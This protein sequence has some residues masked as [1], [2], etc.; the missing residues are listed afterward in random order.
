MKKII[1][2][3]IIICLLLSAIPL[4]ICGYEANENN[5]NE[6]NENLFLETSNNIPPFIKKLGGTYNSDDVKHRFSESEYVPGEMII[7]FKDD[8]EVSLSSSE[9][10][11]LNDILT[12]PAFSTEAMTV[13]ATSSVNLDEVMDTIGVESSNYPDIASIVGSI[14]TS[15]GEVMTTGIESID[16]LNLMCGVKLIEKLTE[17][18]SDASLSNVYKFTFDENV[19]IMSAID[20][21]SNDSNVEFAE[22]NYIYQH[23]EVSNELTNQIYQ[24]KPYIPSYIP[25]DPYFDMQW[26]LHNVGQEGGTPG[27]DIDAPEAWDSGM[28]DDDIVI[29]IVDS[30]VDYTNPD[31]GG[32]TDGITE[33]KFDNQSSHPMNK[34]LEVTLDFAEIFHQYDFDAVSLHFSKIDLGDWS[35]ITSGPIDSDSPDSKYLFDPYLQ[36]S[37]VEDFWTVFTE[38]GNLKVTIYAHD[39]EN[40]WGYAIDKVKLL[41]WKNVKQSEGYQ[42]KFVDGY[43]FFCHDP[44][45]MDDLGHGTHCAGIAAATIDN[46]VGVAGIAGNCKI[47][48]I[49]VGSSM[50]MTESAIARGIIYAANHGAD[51]ISMSIGGPESKLINH[52]LDYAYLKGVVLIAAAGNYDL[53]IKEFAYPAANEKVIAVAATNRYD[54]KAGFS[55]YGSWVDLAAP[56]WDILSLRAY[57]TDMYLEAEGYQPGEYFVPAFDKNAILYRAWG[58]SMSCPH[59]AGVVALILS[60][61]S[62]LKPREVLTILKSSCDPVISDDYIGVGR[63]NASQAV[64]KTAPVIAEFDKSID[65]AIVEGTTKIKGTAKGDR[66]EEYVVEWG[67]GTYPEEWH[68]IDGFSAPKNNEVLVSWNT[69]GRDEGLYSLRLTMNAGGYTYTDITFVIVDNK[70]NTYYVDDNADPSWYNEENHF[71]NIQDAVLLCSNKDNIFVYR[72]TYNEQILLDVNKMVTIQGEDRDTTIIRNM[73]KAGGTIEIYAGGI[74]ISNFTIK[75]WNPPGVEDYFFGI[76]GVYSLDS[77]ISNC[78]FTDCSE[79]FLETFTESRIKISGNSFNCYFLTI[80][81]GNK[82]V[83]MNNVLNNGNIRI[84]Y[85]NKNDIHDNT[86]TDGIFIFSSNNNDVYDNTITDGDLV[87]GFF[88]AISHKNNIYGNTILNGN[89]YIVGRLNY[90]HDNSISTS[91]STPGTGSIYLSGYHWVFCSALFNII[92]SN[93]ISNVDS[94]SNGIILDGAGVL[95]FD[96]SGSVCKFNVISNNDVSNCEI[97]I[98]LL[99]ACNNIVVG[100]TV[101]YSSRYGMLL[102]TYQC[103]PGGSII[104]STGNKLY[105]NNFIENYQHA[106]NDQE[107]KNNTWYCPLSKV[108]NYWDDYEEKYPDAKIINRILLPDYWNTPYDIP[109]G[110]Q[111]LYPLVN[112]QGGSTSY[113]G[114]SQPNSQSTS[115]SNTQSSP[116]SQ[117]GY[118]TTQSTTGSTTRK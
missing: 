10:G 69:I 9:V 116:T 110:V 16:K 21:Y 82:H 83:I 12:L 92:D 26:A 93:T 4:S 42:S 73:N 68:K 46:L 6:A 11:N 61:N 29:A 106:S 56:G 51:I 63:I 90:I 13:G 114:Q 60:K 3:T 108:G 91:S 34:S 66:F 65:Y 59:I 100:N 78:I 36:G 28:G 20:E 96:G 22:P 52:A 89:L 18:D 98:G 27:A 111:D 25:N 19:D 86:L 38:M 112:Q 77:E 79:V 115:Q 30:G 62:G 85:S 31:L 64:Q 15:T 117:P 47:M 45:P 39:C 53:N 95:G 40:E 97:G 118:S 71:D 14:S 50:G 76:E 41:K 72:G 101:S 1:V 2:S 88:L 103:G 70:A 7:K 113:N 99:G 104:Y 37:S 75:S 17:N 33:V 80:Q 49:R 109:V 74:K 81:G 55:N 58:T 23:C 44:D 102:T 107:N 43:D 67:R 54:E 87:I 105:K 8:V 57:A 94:G 84:F 5:A 35:Y 48:P 24:S 32:C